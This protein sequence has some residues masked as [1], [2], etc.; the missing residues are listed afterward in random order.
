MRCTV[1]ATLL[2]TPVVFA[3]DPTPLA[4]PT[5]TAEQKPWTRWWWLGSTVDEAGITKHLERFRDAGFGGVEICPIYGAK[6]SEDKYIDFLSP[7]WLRMLAHTTAE[8]KRLGLGVDM[9]TGTGWP[10]GGPTVTA[11]D[12]SARVVLKRYEL[13]GGATLAEKLPTGKLRAL[14]AVA[15]D[16]TTH[17]LTERMK[18]G[19]LDWTA[20]AGAWKLYAVVQQSPVMK[21]K[22]A[23]PGGVGN[24][25]DPFSTAKLDRYLS[26]FDKAFADYKGLRPRAQFHDSYEYYNV[27][28]T[29]DLFAEFA[30]RRGYD[31]RNHLPA[32]FG[33]GDQD[34][35][36]RQARLPRDDLRPAH[37]LHQAVDRMGACPRRVDA[38][39]GP[40]RADQPAR[41][42]RRGRHPRDGGLPQ[43]D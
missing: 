19:K 12:A 30:V 43:C 13:A 28:W 27:Q 9:T 38:Q 41:R 5:P 22:R 17:D 25:L 10:F 37:R 8:A 35:V 36:V 32:L 7:K 20:P 3:A 29:D 11:D 15:A 2:C 26:V 21:V 34:K 39:S 1:L 33:D 16:G 42:L 18:D 40:R 14:R 6:G 24:V 31:L 23:A 4:W